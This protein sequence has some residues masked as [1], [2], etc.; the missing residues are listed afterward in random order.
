MELNGTEADTK[1][2]GDDLIRLTS[3]HQLEYLTF[4]GQ[5][6]PLLGGDRGQRLAKLVGQSRGHFT[7]QR[8]PRDV[9]QFRL[10][11]AVLSFGFP[12]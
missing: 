4:P 5:D 2:A 11:L 1:M 10:M 7:G 3:G 9:S 6:S 8:N 12:P